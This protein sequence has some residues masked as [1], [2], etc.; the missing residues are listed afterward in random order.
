MPLTTYTFSTGAGGGDQSTSAGTE[1]ALP[2][3][4]FSLTH[5][6][7]EWVAQAREKSSSQA[8]SQAGS[9][10]SADFTVEAPAAHKP[11][12][13]VSAPIQEVLAY[14]K[15][16]FEDANLLDAIP[17]EE[18][19]NPGAWHAWRSYRGLPKIRSGTTSPRIDSAQ[20]T[21]IAHKQPSDW[22]WE[23]VW[24]KRASIGIENSMSEATLFVKAQETSHGQNAIR[25]QKLD[26]EQIRTV[27][28]EALGW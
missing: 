9:R 18:A 7:P 4:T 26:E 24:E 12:A 11:S 27:R 28:R 23:G 22:N 16:A 15:S 20:S 1:E 21:T 10:L 19:V 3:G 5:G 25:F 13:P 6:F 17:L 14:L 2:S 8:K